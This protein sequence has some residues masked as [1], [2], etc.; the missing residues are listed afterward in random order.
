MTLAFAPDHRDGAPVCHM[1]T[2]DDLLLDVM[3][4][5]EA[6][7]GGCSNRWY[8]YAH[9]SATTCTLEPTLDLRVASGADRGHPPVGSPALAAHAGAG[10]PHRLGGALR[11][12]QTARIYTYIISRHPP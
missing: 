6:I 8:A 10:L 9:S 12:G 2:A 1:R 5:D 7:L 11:S 4:L 3:P